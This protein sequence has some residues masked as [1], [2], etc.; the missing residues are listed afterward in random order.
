MGWEQ[1]PRPSDPDHRWQ[2]RTNEA[3]VSRERDAT[4]RRTNGD[5]S[6]LWRR[7]PLE[8]YDYEIARLT[9]LAHSK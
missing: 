9:K 7:Y 1:V 5:N 2:K 3:E 8:V 4:R 6:I